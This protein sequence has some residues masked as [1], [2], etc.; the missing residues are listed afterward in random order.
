MPA[1]EYIST[2]SQSAGGGLNAKLEAGR[3]VVDRAGGAV[4]AVGGDPRVGAKVYG[5]DV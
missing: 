4:V 5:G 3:L 1:P 2:R